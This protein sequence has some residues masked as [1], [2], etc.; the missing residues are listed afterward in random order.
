MNMAEKTSTLQKAIEVVEA[1]SPD[2]QAILIDI[3]DK[4]LKQPRRLEILQA[5]AES[6]QEYAEGKVRSGSVADL[7]KE[8]DN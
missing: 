6:R 4:R 1:L 5:V 8:L 7:L 2:E 3:I